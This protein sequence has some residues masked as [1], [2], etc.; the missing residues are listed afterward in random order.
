MKNKSLGFVILVIA[1]LVLLLLMSCARS[2]PCSLQCFG[3]TY[4]WKSIVT[5]N[6][7][8]IKATCYGFH[9]SFTNH[10]T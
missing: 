6:R 10:K 4:V 1:D 9:N 8:Q 3:M 2:C 7:S 5:T